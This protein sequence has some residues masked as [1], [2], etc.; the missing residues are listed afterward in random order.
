MELSSGAPYTEMCDDGD[1]PISSNASNAQIQSDCKV[2]RKTSSF[3]KGQIIVEQNNIPTNHKTTQKVEF[4]ACD[5]YKSFVKP[6]LGP[7]VFMY[8]SGDW[9]WFEGWFYI[10]LLCI[11]TIIT[12][13]YLYV[14]DP[15]LLKERQK[16]TDD[17]ADGWVHYIF[18]A[19]L[20]S[21]YFTIPL[22]HRFKWSEWIIASIPLFEGRFY[23]S[24]FTG[25]KWMAFVALLHGHIFLFGSFLQNTFLAPVLRIQSEREQTVISHGLYGMVRHP[26]YAGI[27]LVWGGA[28]IFCES[29]LGFILVICIV[30]MVNLRVRVEEKMLI[31]GLKGYA[32]YMDMVRC[33]FVPMS[34]ALFVYPLV[35]L[36]VVLYMEF[37][38][39]R[40]S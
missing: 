38:A 36:S 31:K 39:E 40:K 11:G 22:D 34:Y 18:I 24:L 2:E 6:L 19:L 8:L 30:I 35:I 16:I 26:M 4:T 17:S 28:A 37:V 29:I 20:F 33:R 10:S 1:V 7:L 25:I 9:S 23:M 3:Q 12:N 21:M 13:L 14:H 5:L 27:I 15:V 32:N